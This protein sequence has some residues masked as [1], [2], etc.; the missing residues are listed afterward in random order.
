MK[1]NSQ[2]RFVELGDLCSKHE[3]R[4]EA[5]LDQ[6]SAHRIQ[7]WRALGKIKSVETIA[8]LEDAWNEA[9]RIN[10]DEEWQKK[11]LKRAYD[12]QRQF[13]AQQESLK[14]RDQKEQ[15]ARAALERRRRR[16]EKE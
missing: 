14:Q 4:C 5:R 3:S 2:K 12:E 15:G 9:S 8:Q 10:F 1:K 6:T 16:Q 7:Q 11:M 13:L